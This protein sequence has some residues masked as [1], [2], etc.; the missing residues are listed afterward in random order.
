MGADCGTVRVMVS[1][2]HRNDFLASGAESFNGRLARWVTTHILGSLLMFDVAFTV[3]LVALLPHMNRLQILVVLIFSGWIQSW[4]L[5]A[6]QRSQLVIQRN[7]DAKAD[8]DHH[9]LER[10]LDLSLQQG[11]DIAAIRSMVEKTQR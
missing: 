7:Q 5:F 10:V 4:G 3:P 2:R 11:I 9:N 1:I 6:L 8:A